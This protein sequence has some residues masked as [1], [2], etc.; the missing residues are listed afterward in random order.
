MSI[1][2]SSLY[3]ITDKFNY[4]LNIENFMNIDNNNIIELL[5]NKTLTLYVDKFDVISTN[6]FNFV[7]I[8]YIKCN[9]KKYIN[10]KLPIQYVCDYIDK[11]INLCKQINGKFLKKVKIQIKNIFDTSYQIIDYIFMNNKYYFDKLLNQ[12]K[13]ISISQIQDK[14][15]LEY[16]YLHKRNN[17]INYFTE[18]YILIDNN[19]LIDIICKYYNKSECIELINKEYIL[20]QDISSVITLLKKYKLIYKDLINI[21]TVKNIIIENEDEFLNFVININS[22]TC[23]K[24]DKINLLFDVLNNNDLI[25]LNILNENTITDIITTIIKYNDN[26]ISDETFYKIVDYLIKSNT[27][28]NNLN[29]IFEI[30]KSPYFKHFYDKSVMFKNIYKMYNYKNDNIIVRNIL[31]LI[32]HNID[33]YNINELLELNVLDYKYYTRINNK[34]YQTDFFEISFLHYIILTNKHQAVI[35]KCLDY[36]PELINDNN[37]KYGLYPIHCALLRNNLKIFRNIC[38]KQSRPYMKIL[39]NLHRLPLNKIQEITNDKKMDD[40]IFDGNGNNLLT[41]C[42]LNNCNE[43]IIKILLCNFKYNIYYINNN[44]ENIIILCIRI[45]NQ[46]YIKILESL[47]YD[48]NIGIAYFIQYVTNK[49]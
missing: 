15:F 26:Y 37:N 19:E 10:E 4:I 25:K 31:R 40:N 46:E 12:Y 44:C 18:K 36:F 3:F 49:F 30:K 39:Y 27:I 34:N 28:I 32:F 45:N 41:F 20:I 38:I 13:Y 1:T 22:S 11:C 48:I 14:S 2:I 35:N 7:I 23:N 5:K 8:N 24:E 6:K 42:M 21:L 47:G 29:N 16:I 33:Y 9:I 43:K 17:L